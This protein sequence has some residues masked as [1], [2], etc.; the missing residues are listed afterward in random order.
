MIG[1]F[2]DEK[3]DYK[4]SRI[5]RVY[6]LA[7]IKVLVETSLDPESLRSIVEAANGDFL[8]HALNYVAVKINA[9]SIK[10][11][12]KNQS[13]IKIWHVDQS[14]FETYVGALKAFERILEDRKPVGP[15]NLSLAPPLDKPGENCFNPQEPFNVGTKKLFEA[16]YIPVVAAGNEGNLGINTLNPWSVAPWVIGVGAA[17]VDGK[18]LES[19]SSIG[20]PNSSLYHPTV[21]GPGTDIVPHPPDI[22]KTPEQIKIDEELIPEDLLKRSYTVFSGTSCATANISGAVA[23]IVPYLQNN[24]GIG[25]TEH[26]NGDSK[27]YVHHIDLAPKILELNFSVGDYHKII[28]VDVSSESV[29]PLKVKEILTKIAVPMPGYKQHEIGAGFT[30]RK[31]TEKLFGKHDITLGGYKITND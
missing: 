9:G 13:V 17:T 29:L 28:H 20:I 5:V 21:V 26:K 23:N 4:I 15:V 2:M 8:F 19:Y 25:K 7:K 31:I 30:S 14:I 16:G 27:V 10:N 18:K 11:L 22:P 24:F 3:L 6:P 1:F 12:T